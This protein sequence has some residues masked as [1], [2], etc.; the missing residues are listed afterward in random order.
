MGHWADD[1]LA[2]ID[3]AAPGEIVLVGSSMGGWIMLLAALARPARVRGLVGIA[4]AP[5]FTEDAGLVGR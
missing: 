2:V 4:A 1:A 3:H 5:D